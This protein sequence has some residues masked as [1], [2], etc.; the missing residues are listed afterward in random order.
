MNADE[1]IIRCLSTGMMMAGVIEYVARIAVVPG[2]QHLA[3]LSMLVGDCY[4]E[5]W[6]NEHLSISPCCKWNYKCDP[7]YSLQYQSSSSI[8]TCSS[9]LY[10]STQKCR[11]FPLIYSMFFRL[12]NRFLFLFYSLRLREQGSYSISTTSPVENLKEVFLR[13]FSGSSTLYTHPL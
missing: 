8:C 9:L 13:C 7:H 6:L 5:A 12:W 2:N 10:V 4:P 1:E 11:G 3:L